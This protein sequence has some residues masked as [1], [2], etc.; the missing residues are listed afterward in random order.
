MD[1]CD[2]LIVGGGPAGSSLAWKLQKRGLDVVVLDKSRF[3]R[4]KVC[5]G[6]ITPAALAL[7]Q[8]D[9]DEYSRDNVLQRVTGFRTGMMGGSGVL[10]RYENTVSY[11]IRRSEFDHYLLGRSG[12]RLR[13]G[14][15]LTTMQRGNGSWVVNNSVKTPLVVGAG[16]HF[17]PVSRFL[18]GN[19]ERNESV[20]I[21]QE[22]EFEMDGAQQG[23]CRV[24]GDTPELYFCDDLKGY[25]WCVR[26]GNFLNI[27][28]GRED[29]LN[30][31]EH[32]KS[33][34]DY[35]KEK[36][37]VPANVPM[38]FR[39]H[40][41]ALYRGASQSTVDDGVMLIGDAAALAYPKSGEGIR[42]AIESAFLAADVILS[43]A[44]KYQRENLLPYPA[45]LTERFG[46]GDSIAE[47]LPQPLRRFMSRRLMESG[48]F[49]RHVLLDR[50][51]LNI[52]Q[53]ALN[54]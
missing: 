19:R 35:L 46:K 3:P 42:P 1:S 52:H 45:L 41:Y 7:L 24:R 48:W 29:S 44:G 10:T 50:W 6:W 25:G 18:R 2:V 40:A 30:L 14:E 17:C 13:L 15:P 23:D 26:K 53:P 27:G 38:N 28:L 36:K 5:A 21:A 39:G 37:R 9:E 16:G 49:T 47:M 31:A 54:R 12:A 4:D 32:V 20:V 51:F 43:A 8:I 22:V 34:C 11:G 33:F